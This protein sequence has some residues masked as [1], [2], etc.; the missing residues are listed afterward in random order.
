MRKSYREL[1][2]QRREEDILGIAAH[3][4]RENGYH[5]L[6]M[7]EL[8]EH[9][10]ISKST[11]Y[12]HFRSKEEMVQRVINNSFS[13]IEAH[14]HSI[15]GEPLDRLESL[16]RYVLADSQKPGGFT[17]AFVRGEVVSFFRDDAVII[18]QM[19]DMHIHLSQLIH[20]G[21]ER[22]Q[23]RADLSEAL[24]VGSLFSMIGLLHAPMLVA[25]AH[26]TASIIDQIVHMWRRGIS[27]D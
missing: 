1:A 24:I 8:S 6:N 18:D 26:D 4:I 16:L 19:R 17:G 23:I 9:V 20:E 7:D 13:Q 27:A 10:G 15:D 21:K 25:E 11:L 22:G 2:R 5:S 3:L 12:Q 14:L